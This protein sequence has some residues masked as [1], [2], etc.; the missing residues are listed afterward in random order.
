MRSTRPRE[1]WKL[2]KRKKATTS[3]SVTLQELEEHFKELASDVNET[4][5]GDVEDFLNNF[6][7]SQ[8]DTPTFPELDLSITR[9]EILNSIKKLKQN[10]A[11]GPD[12]LLNEYFIESANI[13][14]DHLEILFNRILDSK[15]F[16]SV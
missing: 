8:P 7:T 2:F 14:C 11:H 4:L 13:L 10:K 9:K 16:P 3:G 1:F 5:H 12:T 15:E 6:D